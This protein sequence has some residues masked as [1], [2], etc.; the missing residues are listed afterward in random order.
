M[1][2]K[3]GK[4]TQG[5]LKKLQEKIIKNCEPYNKKLEKETDEVKQIKL[6][7]KILQIDFKLRLDA[8]KKLT[9]KEWETLVDEIY[10]PLNKQS[11]LQETE[12]DEIVFKR[13]KNSQEFKTYEKQKKAL[14]QTLEPIID[15]LNDSNLNKKQLTRYVQL[16]IHSNMTSLVALSQDAIDFNT[17]HEAEKIVKRRLGFSYDWLIGL[18]LIQLHE[19]LIKKK[20]ESYG[21]KIIEDES[22]NILMK[23]LSAL[24]RKKERLD[25]SI[26]LLMTNGIK[27]T[28]DI[29]SHEGYKYSISKP[30]LN[31]I[32]NELLELE[33]ILYPEE[34]KNKQN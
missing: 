31:K 26:D 6:I 4:N 11:I 33:R 18:S 5:I 13:S 3:P 28:R 23:K 29:M 15:I 9:D 32:C 2:K 22:I 10:E 14:G 17:F 16:L 20:L 19:N 8:I 30:Q 24:I 27:K 7:Q 12:S 25:V 34:S 21:E 1:Q